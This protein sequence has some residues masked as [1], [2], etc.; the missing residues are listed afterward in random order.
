MQFEFF[1]SIGDIRNRFFSSVL[2][3]YNI[4]FDIFEA[5]GSFGIVKI[6]PA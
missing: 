5:W 3:Y 4:C 1:L 2:Q 6:I